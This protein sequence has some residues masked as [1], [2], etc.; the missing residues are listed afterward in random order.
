[1]PR[2][3][4]EPA[5]KI[6]VFGSY[7]LIVAG[8]GPAGLGA[9]I[10]GARSG[11]K[12]VLLIERTACLG[13]M[14]TAGLV[15]CFCPLSWK[16]ARPLI[17]GITAE[18]LKRLKAA[19]GNGDP[20]YDQWP[21][22][23]A[24]KL[25]RIYDQLAM[26]ADVEVLF[27]TQVSGIMGTRS[28]LKGLIIENKGGRQAVLGKIFVDATGDADIAAQAGVPFAKGDEKGRMMGVTLCFTI[29][30]INDRQYQRWVRKNP[31]NRE[32]N[33]VLIAAEK[34]RQLPTYADAENRMIADICLYPDVRAYNFGHIFGID[35]T[36]PAD[37][38]RTMIRGREI[39]HNF[40]AFARKHIPGMADAKI[41]ATALLPGVRETR[42]IEG[43]A[44]MTAQH[45]W[46]QLIRP[47]TIALY[48][49]PVDVHNVKKDSNKNRVTDELK[50]LPPGAYYGLPYG[51]MVPRGPLTNLLVAGRSVSAD[52]VANG[53]IRPMP[54]C[55]ALGQAAGVA[56]A[57]AIRN[58]TSVG[59]VNINELRKQLRKQGARVE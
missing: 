34:A 10:A 51:I 14:G 47:D 22:L 24:E 53:S 30:G 41:V 59:A 49:Y 54:S 26:E 20:R 50:A 39:A 15:P 29:A 42:R 56:A 19:G 40:V 52:R 46:D 57:I 35:G 36:N 2:F 44:T 45:Y 16:G 31:T 55:I 8:G 5:R 25:K 48:D 32:K 1:M 3:V 21:P 13:G 58:R 9:A 23:D 7:D 37:L 27:L 18:V 28:R 11:L 43:K 6:P 4:I 17:T 38:S 12:K 33:A